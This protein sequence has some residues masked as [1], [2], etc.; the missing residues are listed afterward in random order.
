[1]HLT[2][3]APNPRSIKDSSKSVIVYRI[4]KTR[5]TSFDIVEEMRRQIEREEAEK[6]L[7]K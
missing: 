2:T 3:Q 5:I 4:E 6:N 7:K 1:M